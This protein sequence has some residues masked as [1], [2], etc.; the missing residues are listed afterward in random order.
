MAKFKLI[1]HPISETSDAVKGHLMVCLPKFGW[2]F[3]CNTLENKQ[4][5]I[6]EGKYPVSTTFSPK[7][8][9]NLPLLSNVPVA[10]SGPAPDEH[11]S[12]RLRSPFRRRS[13]IRVHRG[14]K[15]QHSRG[16]ILV[17]DRLYEDIVM[18]FISDDSASEMEVTQGCESNVFHH[19]GTEYE[20]ER[21][22]N[23]SSRVSSPRSS[24]RL[25]QEVARYRS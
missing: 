19:Y 8:K 14:T 16:C 9:R 17:N 5:L 22:A 25:A 15:P 4:Y 6:P 20:S 3:I 23:H 10:G 2:V 13:G 11:G 1:R 24:L 21:M 12:S 18:D 7:F